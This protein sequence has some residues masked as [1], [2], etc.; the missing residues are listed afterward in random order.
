MSLLHLFSSWVSCLEHVYGEEIEHSN[1]SGQVTS[2]HRIAPFYTE[3]YPYLAKT[4]E[5]TFYATDFYA[6]ASPSST[7]TF[8]DYVW[9]EGFSQRSSLVNYYLRTL[10][11][12]GQLL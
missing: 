10:S 2:N 7:N 4:F 6:R 1:V 12:C 3:P 9:L 11:R 8:V 5:K